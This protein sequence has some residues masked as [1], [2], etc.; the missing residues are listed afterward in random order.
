MLENLKQTAQ[1]LV[2][3]RKLNIAETQVL[4]KI[5]ENRLKKT[6]VTE[7]Q[8]RVKILITKAK[9]TLKEFEREIAEYQEVIDE[10]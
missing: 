8:N 3:K 7:D 1:R 9:D 6:D 5:F 10:M 4:I 2:E